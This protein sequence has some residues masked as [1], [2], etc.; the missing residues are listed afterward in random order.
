MPYPKYNNYTGAKIP[1]PPVFTGSMLETAHE[2]RKWYYENVWTTL[3]DKLKGNQTS[4]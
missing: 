2:W 4:H 1:Q 3:P